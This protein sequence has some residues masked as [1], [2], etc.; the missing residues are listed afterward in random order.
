MAFCNLLYCYYYLYSQQLLLLLNQILTSTTEYYTSFKNCS[1]KISNTT[2]RDFKTVDYTTVLHFS[3]Q[4]TGDI[5]SLPQY[6]VND[7]IPFLNIPFVKCIDQFVSLR[8]FKDSK[9][10]HC[11]LINCKVLHLLKKISHF[12]Y[13]I[14]SSESEYNHLSKLRTKFKSISKLN[15]QVYLIE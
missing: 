14:S 12:P 5:K 15:N 2:Y 11:F 1:Q 9:S 7:S 6:S 10:P 13:I 4:L 3:I 8:V